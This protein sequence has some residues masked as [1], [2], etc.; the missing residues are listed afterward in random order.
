L[1]TSNAEAQGIR[2]ISDARKFEADVIGESEF[3]LELA[4][5]RVCGEVGE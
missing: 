5:L 1:I 2:N 4:R 3:S